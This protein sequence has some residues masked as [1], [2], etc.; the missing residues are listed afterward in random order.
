[1]D[2]SVVLSQGDNWVNFTV[3]VW[4]WLLVWVRKCKCLKHENWLTEFSPCFLQFWIQ[5]HI[6]QLLFSGA[7]TGDLSFPPPWP[8]MILAL[9]PWIGTGT[10]HLLTIAHLC[11]SAFLTPFRVQCGHWTLW[12]GWVLRQHYQMLLPSAWAPRF[13][14]SLQEA[15]FT[16]AP[17]LWKPD[18]F[19]SLSTHKGTSVKEDWN[20]ILSF[21][22]VLPCRLQ[23]DCLHVFLNRPDTVLVA[24]PRS[25]DRTRELCSD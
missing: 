15:F 23:G 6:Y 18:W 4:I 17:T 14:L 10:S 13:L 12:K 8:R 5:K 9:G 1:M 19:L 11:H 25:K 22:A 24:I 20:H 3:D 16:E 2:D 7:C 21:L